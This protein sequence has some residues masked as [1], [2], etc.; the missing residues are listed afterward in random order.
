MKSRTSEVLAVGGKS[1]R[2]GNPNKKRKAK[3]NWVAPKPVAKG[4]W[5]AP[6][7]VGKK[8][9]DDKKCFHSN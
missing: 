1:P 7:P 2:N 3:G 6:K 9:K 5:V 4:N 8:T